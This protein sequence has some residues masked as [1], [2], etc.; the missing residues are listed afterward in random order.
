[1]YCLSG[2]VL[3]L[4][5]LLC[6]VTDRPSNNL[7]Q[8]VVIFKEGHWIV[9]YIY[10]KYCSNKK[11]GEERSGLAHRGFRTKIGSL[12]LYLK[13]RLSLARALSIDTSL[14]V[15]TF[16]PHL[17]SIL[18]IKALDKNRPTDGQQ[19]DLIRVFLSLNGTEP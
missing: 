3:T 6:V 13:F 19:N 18:E 12:E 8:I 9:K 16:I 5:F 15:A 10:V 14:E 17:P 4:G 2:S 1:M 11:T 7:Q